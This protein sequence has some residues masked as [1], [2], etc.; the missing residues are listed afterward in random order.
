MVDEHAVL[1]LP[2]YTEA[3]GNY[4]RTRNE[5]G[6]YHASLLGKAGVEASLG[7]DEIIAL[8]AEALEGALEGL[9]YRQVAGASVDALQFLLEVMI[10]YGVQYQQFLELRSQEQIREAQRL[11]E[12]KTLLLAT[13][14]HEMRTPITVAQGTLDLASRSLA[15]RQIDQVP[16]LLESARQALTR[17][18]RLTADLYEA[19]R[20]ENP[21]IHLEP[22]DLI[23]IVCQAC[24]WAQA[25]AAEKG[26]A[27]VSDLTASSITVDGDADALLS[28]FSNLLSNAIRYTPASGHVTVRD[29]GDDNRVWIDVADTGMGM[30]AE[31]RQHVFDKFYRAPEARVIESQ[32]LGLGLSLARHLVLG[33]GGELTVESTAGEGSTFRVILPRRTAHSTHEGGPRHDDRSAAP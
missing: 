1:S 30:T 24:Q 7:P 29:G 26:I 17:L 8:H 31:V 22:Q 11:N 20:G 15:R 3:L 27:L 10:A 13:V 28:V 6:L 18:S 25:P 14:S 21:Q 5:A 9:S 4:I 2:S 12:E 19:S 32:G 16:T 23:T 33:H